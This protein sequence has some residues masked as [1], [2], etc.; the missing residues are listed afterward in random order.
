MWG[1]EV[2]LRMGGRLRLQDDAV[3]GNEAAC[4]LLVGIVCRVWSLRPPWFT[5]HAQTCPNRTLHSAGTGARG[6]TT[7]DN[8]P[9]IPIECD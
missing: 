7:N 2:A 6:G 5:D 1:Q 3:E 4:A 8:R 9:K